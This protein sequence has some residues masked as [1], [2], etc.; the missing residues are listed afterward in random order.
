MTKGALLRGLARILALIGSWVLRRLG[1]WSLV[2]VVAYLK[3]RAQVFA[4]KGKDRDDAIGA[5]YRGRAERWRKVA[6]WLAKRWPDAER[7]LDEADA[8]ARAEIDKIP[9]HVDAEKKPR[10]V[11]RRRPR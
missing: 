6:A 8:L 11:R 4:E 9:E 7:V 10:A 1:Q 3:V 5:W 2:E